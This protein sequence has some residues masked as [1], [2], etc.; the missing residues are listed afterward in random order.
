MDGHAS[1]AGGS[2]RPIILFC[3]CH[4]S[5]ALDEDRLAAALSEVAEVRLTDELCRGQ[6]AVFEQVVDEGRSV[7]VSCTQELPLFA[8]IWEESDAEAPLQAFNIRELAGWSREGKEALPKI[9]ALAAAAL[10]LAKAPPVPVTEVESLGRCLIA[11][12]AEPALRLAALLEEALAV[13]VLITGGLEEALPPPRMSWPL[14]AGR[15]EGVSG[16]FGGFTVAVAEAKEYLPWHREGLAFAAGSDGA[17]AA[18]LP[19]EAWDIVIE[20][21]GTPRFAPHGREGYLHVPA[22]A[23]G[24]VREA[25]LLRT[26]LK[27]RDLVGTFER[28]LHAR[29]EPR[30]CAHARNG[31]TGCRRCLEACPTGAIAPAGDFVQV[32]PRICEGCGECAAVCPSGA[33]EY[34]TPALQPLLARMR[35]AL[36][37]HA[38]AGGAPPVLLLHEGERVIE[39]LALLARYSDGLPA[40]V[41]P[42][43]LHSAGRVGHALV[44]AAMASGAARVAVLAPADRAAE[45]EPLQRELDLAAAI[46]EGLGYPSA[47]WP[48]WLASDD[49]FEIGDWLWGLDIP[50]L[51]LPTAALPLAGTQREVARHAM[52]ALAEA[53]GPSGAGDGAAVISLPAGS[54]YGRIEVDETRCTLCLACV[55]ACP[56][57]ALGDDPER[58]RLRFVEQACLQCGLCRRTCP[59]GAISLEARLDLSPTA[60]DWQVLVEDAP[61]TCAACGKAF[62]SRRA[63]ERVIARLEA[64]GDPRLSDPARLRLLRYC[65]DCRVAAMVMEEQGQ[66]PFALGEVP[67]PRV[68]EDYL[69]GEAATASVSGK[70]NDDREEKT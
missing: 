19:H 51:P 69:D 22:R 63:V 47:A 49:P 68:T 4:G 14:L 18:A 34:A 67:R 53:A 25:D 36:R 24:A 38:A 6:L 2:G 26:A 54:P 29:C 16:H 35:A 27:A 8:E 12:P 20:I 64:M 11:G 61:M 13:T 50:D 48:V 66:A 41:L 1:E 58:P 21:G 23:D 15:L 17:A 42:I 45:L 70:K 28:P 33:M 44:L 39:R 55:G 65:E 56:A 60:A 59:E 7:L 5:V 37:T 40:R 32:D 43:S 52:L 62:G 31:I 46:L 3:S 9:A 30:R 10:E 57:G